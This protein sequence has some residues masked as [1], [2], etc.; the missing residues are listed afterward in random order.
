MQPTEPTMGSPRRSIS[1]SSSQRFLTIPTLPQTPFPTDTI[2]SC[3][4]EEP[5][6]Q[7]SVQDSK[8]QGVSS[9]QK[10]MSTLSPQNSPIIPIDAAVGSNDYASEVQSTDETI[11]HKS[12]TLSQ[13]KELSE[14]TDSAT[15]Y[16]N[17]SAP[18]RTSP[19][20]HMDIGSS[21]KEALEGFQGSLPTS[22]H[23]QLPN[24]PAHG[25][26]GSPAK[27]T[28][29]VHSSHASSQPSDQGLKSLENKAQNVPQSVIEEIPWTMGQH[30]DFVKA[31]FSLGLT[32]CSPSVIMEEMKHLPKD[33]SR[34]NIKSHLQKFR[35]TTDKSVA[36]FM[37]EFDAFLNRVDAEKLRNTQDGTALNASTSKERQVS[38]DSVDPL[39][40]LTAGSDPEE[41]LGG[42]AAGY[43]AYAVGHNY[44][45][46][47]DRNMIIYEGNP[48]ELPRLSI[49]EQKSSL[50]QSLKQVKGALD[51]VRDLLLKKR[52]GIPFRI[53]KRIPPFLN[54]QD[55]AEHFPAYSRYPTDLSD[56]PTANNTYSAT[57]PTHISMSGPAVPTYGPPYHHHHYPA[58]DGRGYPYPAPY[59][60]DDGVYGSVPG[61]GYHFYHEPHHSTMHYPPPPSAM[62]YPLPPHAMHYPPPPPGYPSGS[63]PFNTYRIPSYIHPDSAHPPMSDYPPESMH[64]PGLMYDSHIGPVPHY[65]GSQEVYFEPPNH[66]SS[67]YKKNELESKPDSIR[68]TNARNISGGIY[69]NVSSS[70]ANYPSDTRPSEESR[71][72]K[73]SWSPITSPTLNETAVDKRGA[74]RQKPDLKVDILADCETDRPLSFELADLGLDPG[75]E[76]VGRRTDA[77]TMS[78]AD[79]QSSPFSVMSALRNARMQ[80]S[81]AATPD[82]VTLDFGRSVA[83]P[84]EDDR[85]PK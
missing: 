70:R 37:E 6:D 8:I 47:N 50:G 71:S 33:I 38:S 81:P 48:E 63:V 80:P 5:K 75:R 53:D 15:S 27:N 41:L 28:S 46:R 2:T 4:K 51:F 36:D 20:I 64:P 17:V 18:E 31:V 45:P 85:Y 13:H 25:N 23:I 84:T 56:Q 82:R 10:S 68:S 16:S 60:T 52:H 69:A 57:V 79:S 19:P 40:I 43:A 49:S 30:R 3:L 72:T 59:R 55:V 11:P 62:H 32:H 14:I 39:E 61:H 12:T 44:A 77:L 73:R 9:P 22:H 54:K 24:L 83:T 26:E 42:E 29:T 76:P 78:G 74:K 34:E 67:Y 58:P 21:H 1:P 35:K 65:Q 7:D 66:M